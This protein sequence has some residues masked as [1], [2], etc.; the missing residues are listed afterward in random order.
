LVQQSESPR[1]QEAI[2]HRPR[3]GSSARRLRFPA[4]SQ[5][6]GTDLVTRSNQQ[7]ILLS[8]LIQSFYYFA[9]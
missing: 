8:I 4:L 6:V 1:P 3:D 7:P 9:F 2:E 5:D